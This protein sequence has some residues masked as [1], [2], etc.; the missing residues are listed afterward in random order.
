M[1]KLKQQEKK[2]N[3]LHT[4]RHQS[5]ALKDTMRRYDSAYNIAVSK[6]KEWCSI[7]DLPPDGV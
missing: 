3:D 2:M 4:L 6:Y 7:N 1:K 5:L